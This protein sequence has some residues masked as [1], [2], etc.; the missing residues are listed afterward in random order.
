[1]PHMLRELETVLLGII[2]SSPN[3][4]FITVVASTIR[5]LI[6]NEGLSVSYT[7]RVNME[8]KFP[9]LSSDLL[10]DLSSTAIFE[11]FSECSCVPSAYK[12][13]NV[14]SDALVSMDQ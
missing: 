13:R 12:G 9:S 7:K 1:M 10:Q 5:H 11:T 8:S 14:D 3:C 4:C 2:S 6:L